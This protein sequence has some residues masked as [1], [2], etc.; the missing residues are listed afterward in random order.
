MFAN[1]NTDHQRTAAAHAPESVGVF[2]IE[3]G[4]REAA[5]E[6][7][8]RGVQRVAEIDAAAALAM[9]QVAD[10][11]GVGFG[12][13]RVAIGAQLLAQRLVV[14]DDAVVD[15][16]DSRV[17]KLWM[18]VGLAGSSMGGPA[19]V[20]DPDL[21]VV[22]FTQR[23]GQARDLADR[24]LTQQPA[25]CVDQRQ[26]GRIVA[27]VLQSPQTVDQDCRDVALGNGG[28]NSAHEQLLDPELTR[29]GS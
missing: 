10:D 21:P 19:R 11:F 23:L 27:A 20:R 25:A 15:H 24:A 26:S 16:G 12:F 2:C 1:T 8:N 6:T 22:R 28:Y 4:Q 13:E 5:F 7:G 9:D 3:N 29:A 14:L 18:G 17:R